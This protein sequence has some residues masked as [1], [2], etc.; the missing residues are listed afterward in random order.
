VI[1]ADNRI[2]ECAVASGASAIV[3]GDKELLALGNYEGIGTMTVARLVYT[4]PE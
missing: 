4:L 1:S 3:T 2:L